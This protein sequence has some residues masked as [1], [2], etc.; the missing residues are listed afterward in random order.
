MTQSC[1]YKLY[2][3]QYSIKVFVKY[4]RITERG[5]GEYITIPI[6]NMERPA[7]FRPKKLITIKQAKVLSNCYFVKVEAAI[8][9]AKEDAEKE[10]W[11]IFQKLKDLSQPTQLPIIY[12][13]SVWVWMKLCNEIRRTPNF[14]FAF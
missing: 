2:Q 13:Q 14:D 12:N 6:R 8:R 9:K 4:D 3:V 1:Q 5:E 7:D 10:K 11:N